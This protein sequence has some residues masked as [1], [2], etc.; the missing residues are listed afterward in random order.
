MIKIF[1]FIFLISSVAHGSSY[2]WSCGQTAGSKYFWDHGQT[3]GSKY[4][5]TRGD[6]PGSNYFWDKGVEAGSQYYWKQGDGPG[7]EYF[8]TKGTGPGSAY[9]W[10]HGD[11]PGSMYHW[12]KGYTS[13]VPPYVVS[14]CL[15][16]KVR[17]PLC[18]ILQSALSN[19]SRTN[20]IRQTVFG[21]QQLLSPS[22]NTRSP[23]C[24]EKKED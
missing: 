24:L 23:E 15:S 16:G 6:G 9:Y 22:I 8:Y 1:L 4:Y 19:P 10:V 14:L 11:G 3:A 7:S 12:Q 5:W 2:F 17:I 21:F 13:S 18:E 20:C